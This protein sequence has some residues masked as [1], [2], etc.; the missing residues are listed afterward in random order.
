MSRRLCLLLLTTPLVFIAC[1]EGS[2]SEPAAGEML[3]SPERDASASLG[4]DD[5]APAL[6]GGTAVDAGT[7]DALAA[8]GAPGG[9]AGGASAGGEDT[10]GSPGAGGGG[11]GTGGGA[12]ASGGGAPG[13]GG[14]ADGTTR[15]CL[16]CPAGTQTCAGGAWGACAAPTEI[17]DGADNDC[18]GRADEGFADLGAVCSAGGGACARDGRV[19]CAPGGAATVCDAMAAAPE[20]EAC[21]GADND[22]DG[23]SDEGLAGCCQV[24]GDCGANESCIARACV[25]DALPGCEDVYEA[26]G[27]G[28]YE[29]RTAGRPA[30]HHG[31]CVPDSPAPEMIARFRFPEAEEVE[32]DTTNSGFDTVLHVRTACEDVATEVAC[33][34]DSGQGGGTSRVRFQAEADTDY[35]VMI[36]GFGA[37]EGRFFVS[38][39]P[40]RAGTCAS[41]DLL[42][43]QTS[44]F[45]TTAGASAHDPEG[46]GRGG[47]P[48]RVFAFTAQGNGLLTASTAD[49]GYDTVLYVRTACDDP[50]SEIA[51][52]DDRGVFDTSSSVTFNVEN[53]RTY[54]LFVDGYDGGGD[55]WLHLE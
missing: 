25:R 10:G 26:T 51:C 45:G 2:D 27:F 42:L 13:P 21:D 47:S 44:R 40:V 3:P 52:S 54:Y 11:P 7:P 49:S 24:D 4:T 33:D 29:G 43:W 23:R 34:D 39:W 38:A 15:A 46:C 9:G 1:A 12:A 30:E 8:G 36:D 16:D 37:A 18:D 50:A 5:P 17:C 32:I 41:P 20:A 28:S 31:A 53:G 14:C 19:V 6:G 48:E 55:F 22:C 35:Y